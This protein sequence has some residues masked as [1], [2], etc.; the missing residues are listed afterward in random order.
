MAT[1]KTV[2]IGHRPGPLVR[3]IDD[4][5]WSAANG[6]EQDVDMDLA[7]NLVAYPTADFYIAALT[8]S[9]RKELA[10]RLGVKPE[11]IIVAGETVHE[12]PA[13]KT[14]PRVADLTGAERAQELLDKGY[15]TV[16]DLAALDDEGIEWLATN[17]GA[18]R[19][20]VQA[21]SAAAREQINEGS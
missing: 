19:E 21:W 3:T 9:G 4:Y 1:T 17:T 12:G 6:W 13:V 5:E 18:G 14:E 20:E 7:V 11:N 8:E 15:A 16:G 10:K 2:R